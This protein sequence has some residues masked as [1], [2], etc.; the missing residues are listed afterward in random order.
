MAAQRAA[1]PLPPRQHFVLSA[2]QQKALAAMVLSSLG[3]S[4]TRW[5]WTHTRRLR[6]GT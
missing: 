5:P 1:K 2:K 4:G 6:T 3:S